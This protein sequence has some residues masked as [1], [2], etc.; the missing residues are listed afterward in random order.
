[1][2]VERLAE[3][4]RACFK[5]P[6]PWSAAEFTDLLVSPLC[7]L[8]PHDHGFALGRAVVD[9]AELLTVAVMPE[10]RRKGVGSLLISGF[11][12]EACTRGARRAFLEVAADNVAARKL[13]EGQGFAQSGQR[14]RY[15]ATPTGPIDALIYGR[16]LG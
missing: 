13:Y 11:L 5:A 15:Y 2:T 1:M 7:F 9:E 8:I 16:A 6:R 4:H 10:A 3:I 14:K 12:V